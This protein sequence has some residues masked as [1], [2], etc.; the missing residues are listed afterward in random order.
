[1]YSNTVSVKINCFKGFSYEET[2]LGIKNAGFKYL[3]LSTSKGNSLGLYKD[4]SKEELDN[5]KNDLDK[6]GLEAISVGGNSYIMEDDKSNILANIDIANYLGCKYIVT[7]VFNARN[8]GD[9]NTSDED[10]VEHIKYYLPYLE[11]YNLDLVIELH[12]LYATGK[13]MNRVLEKVNSKH[14]HINYDTGN[15]LFWGKLSVEEML[16]DFKEN[17]NNISYMHLKDKLGAIDEWNFPA[18]GKGYIPVKNIMNIFDE[19]NNNS[20]ISVEIEFTEKGVNDIN[21]VY[22]ALNYSA[23][24]LSEIGLNI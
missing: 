9:S 10:V 12:G 15:A 18:I 11:K 8:D 2:L 5:F 7:T 24:Y 4:M 6:Y 13:T 17:I 19:N 3:E 14:V 21:E 1:M 22:E 23:K 16:S 20:N